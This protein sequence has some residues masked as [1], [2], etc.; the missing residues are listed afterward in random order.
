MVLMAQVL[1]ILQPGVQ[2]VG[3]VSHYFGSLTHL[4]VCVCV[5]KLYIIYKVGWKRRSVVLFHSE[6]LHHL[7]SEKHDN[8]ATSVQTSLD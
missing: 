5:C 8:E 6:C 1:C 3:V 4:C 7:L 2:R